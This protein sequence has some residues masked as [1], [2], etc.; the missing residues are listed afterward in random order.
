MTLKEFIANLER[1][2]KNHSIY[3]WGGGGQMAPTITEAWIKKKENSSTN[4]KRA[5]AFWKK[6]CAAGYAN[7]LRAFDCSGLGTYC[8][9]KS[10]AKANT[11][12]GWTKKITRADLK[13]GDWVFR[14][15]SSGKA[16]HIGY[17]VDTALN[18]IES[19]GRDDGVVRRALNASGVSYWNR[20][21]RPTMFADEINGKS[22]APAAAPSKPAA[23]PA[24][25]SPA[26][27]VAVNPAPA[28]S[29]WVLT[30]LLKKT[31]PLMRGDDVKNAQAALIKNNFSCGKQGA[32]GAFGS[33]TDAAV[34][35]FQRAKKIT[36][37]GVIGKNTCAALGG[38][39]K[40]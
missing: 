35:A 27:P 33:G 32:D 30:R 1:E 3:V 8:L 6:Q 40:G 13:M 12:M 11:M 18:V 39:W 21:G 7:I 37:D 10:K 4:A 22:A 19:K 24:A 28:N 15:D 29:G 9:G 36:V 25:P 26:K 20:C 31:D 17:V 2:V 16:T 38:V 5:I 14:V 34:R 23:V